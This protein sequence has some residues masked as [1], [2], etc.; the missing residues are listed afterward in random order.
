[1]KNAETVIVMAY[2]IEYKNYVTGSYR[3]Y[4]KSNDPYAYGTPFDS[5]VSARKKCI[6]LIENYTASLAVVRGGVEQLVYKIAGGKY[7]VEDRPKD[8]WYYLKRDGTLG[9]P[10]S[11]V[12]RVYAMIIR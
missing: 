7:I 5:V 6:S 10:I 9:S 4:S 11:N 1:M 2:V 12:N 8:K 3:F